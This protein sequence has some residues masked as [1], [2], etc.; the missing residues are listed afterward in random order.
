MLERGVFLNDVFK[1][2]SDPTR[3]K[4]LEML[5]EEELTAGEIFEAFEMTN[6]AISQHLKVLREANLVTSFKH[7]QFVYYSLSTTMMEDVIAWFFSFRKKKG[8]K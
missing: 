7:K 5:K 8:D 4:I 1:A 3:R 6:Q 2:L